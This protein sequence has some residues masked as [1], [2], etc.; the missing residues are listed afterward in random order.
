MPLYISI[1]SAQ[2]FHFLHNLSIFLMV[3]IIIQAV[4]KGRYH[5]LDLHLPG[6]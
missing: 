6:N 1:D 2:G 4:Y 5:A 3:L